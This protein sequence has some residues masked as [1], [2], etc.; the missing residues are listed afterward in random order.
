[1]RTPLTTT[2][3]PASTGGPSREGARVELE[4]TGSSWPRTLSRQLAAAYLSV[5]TREIDRLI[6]IGAIG[7]VRLE[8]VRHP[9]GAATSGTNRGI[10]IDRLELDELVVRSRERR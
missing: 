10:L 5:S 4:V 1:M 9:N 3:R 2:M 8:A 7:I 6:D